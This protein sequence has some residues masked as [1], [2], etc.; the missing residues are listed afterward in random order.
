MLLQFS[1]L[2]QNIAVL[3][4][5]DTPIYLIILNSFG[6]SRGSAVETVFGKIFNIQ[7]EN[8]D[9]NTCSA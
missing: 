8:V 4:I 3:M 5:W 1:D 2:S 6:S 9:H 7:C